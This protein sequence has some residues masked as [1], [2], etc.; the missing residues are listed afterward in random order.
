M[1]LPA[2]TQDLAEYNLVTLVKRTPNGNGEPH[3]VPVA[4]VDTIEVRTTFSGVVFACSLVPTEASSDL[5][6]NI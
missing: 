2:S 1:S 3:V 4:D 6:K 5:G